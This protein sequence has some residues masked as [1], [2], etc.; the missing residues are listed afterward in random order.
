MDTWLP[1]T[2]QGKARVVLIEKGEVCG[3]CLNRG[4]IPTKALVRTTEIC[5]AL[6]EASRYGCKADG[7]EVDF[8]R[9]M[10]RKDRWWLA[11]SKESIPCWR[12]T[13]RRIVS[14]LWYVDR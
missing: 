11:L 14:W 12:V 13:R 3:T 2:E 6:Q 10:A 9:A 7:I 5:K 8:Q 4:C 1:F